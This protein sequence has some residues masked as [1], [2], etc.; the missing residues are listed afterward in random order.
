MDP[1]RVMML[2]GLF[3]L[4]SLLVGEYLKKKGVI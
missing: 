3:L 2:V 4:V 1:A